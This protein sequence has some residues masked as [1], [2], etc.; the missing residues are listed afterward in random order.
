LGQT[1][2]KTVQKTMTIAWWC[3]RKQWTSNNCSQWR[4]NRPSSPTRIQLAKLL[5]VPC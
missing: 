4:L 2:I 5:S 1:V 3:R